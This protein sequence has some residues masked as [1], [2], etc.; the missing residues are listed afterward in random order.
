MTS[1]STR[2]GRS[3]SAALS[4]ARFMSP[5]YGARHLSALG[6]DLLVADQRATGVEVAGKGRPLL[7]VAK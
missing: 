7:T 4:L 6:D 3:S 2:T 1:V 5:F